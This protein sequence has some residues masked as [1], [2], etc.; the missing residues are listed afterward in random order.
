M[1]TDL[2]ARDLMYG[3]VTTAVRTGGPVFFGYVPQMVWPDNPPKDQPDARKTWLRTSRQ[4]VNQRLAAFRDTAKVYETDGILFVQLFF[5][6][7][8]QGSVEAGEMFADYVR[9]AFRG[10]PAESEIVFRNARVLKLG[11]EEKWFRSNVVVEFEFDE[12][13]S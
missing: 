7:A 10:A 8:V 3:A 2:E 4:I 11:N 12:I 9:D 5:P 13:R 1:P 6:R